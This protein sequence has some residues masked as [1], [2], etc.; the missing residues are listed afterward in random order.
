[1]ASKRSAATAR[2]DDGGHRSATDTREGG[3]KR[4]RGQRG[5]EQ[6]R[7]TKAQRRGKA[8]ARAQAAG[9]GRD[10]AD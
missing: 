4:Q 8:K 5:G 10:G 2:A 7:L 9:D 1:M 6:T 3:E